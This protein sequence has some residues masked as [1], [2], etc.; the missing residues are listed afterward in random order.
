MQ[1]RSPTPHRIFCVCVS[2][3]GEPMYHFPGHYDP[4]HYQRDPGF[5]GTRASLA[6]TARAGAAESGQS[7]RVPQRGDGP[8]GYGS[9]PTRT[10]NATRTHSFYAPGPEPSTQNYS[11]LRQGTIDGLATQRLPLEPHAGLG[12]SVKLGGNQQVTGSL[13]PV[14]TYGDKDLWSHPI[15]AK[16]Q[17]LPAPYVP[18]QQS[19]ASSAQQQQHQQAFPASQRFA[20]TSFP[21]PGRA[22]GQQSFGASNG[23]Q[24]A[25]FGTMT[26]SSSAQAPYYQGFQRTTQNGGAYSS[27]ESADALTG[28]VDPAFVD[29]PDQ[30]RYD[31]RGAAMA[32]DVDLRRNT[33]PRNKYLIPGCE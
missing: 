31:A 1:R 27:A 24:T 21:A 32:K 11:A 22:P 19:Y 5:Y 26:S 8:V 29:A 9:A 10:S 25:R 33:D 16:G 6:A 30:W 28:L 18:A 23:S 13:G 12:N 2:S 14:G 20:S 3:S 4:S 7:V 17:T 15:L